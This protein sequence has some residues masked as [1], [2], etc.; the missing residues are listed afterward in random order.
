MSSS[1][2]D[3]PVERCISHLLLK[4]PLPKPGGPAVLVPLPALN[5]PMILSNPPGKDLPLVDLPFQRLFACLDVPTIVTIVV[6]LLSL[7]RKL[8]IVSTRPSLVLDVCE[9]LKALLFPFDLCAPYVPRLTE[10][11]VSCLDFPGAIFVGIFDDGTK[12][13]LASMVRSN[14]PE[15]SAIVDL[16]TGGINCSGDRYEVLK[17]CWNLIPAGPRSILVSEV[18]T[19]CRDAGIVP[20][21]EPLDSQV[22]S[23][24]DISVPFSSLVDDFHDAGHSER[25]PL[26]DR[27]VRDAFLRFFTSALAGYER[28]LVPPDLDFKTSGSEWFDT[29]GFIAAASQEQTPYLNNLVSTQLFQ[30]FIQRRTEDSDVHCLLFDECLIEYHSSSIPYGRLGGDVETV[31]SNNEGPPQMMYSLLVDQCCAESHHNFSNGSFNDEVNESETLQ[32]LPGNDDQHQAESHDLFTNEQGDL[33]TTPA[34]DGLPGFSQYVHV[35]DG[36]PCFPQKLN[37]NY[38]SPKEP[39][40]LL[41][42]ISEAPLPLLTRSEREIEEACRKRK[43]ATS[44]RGLNNQ[45]RC[46]WQ[47]PKLMGSHFLGTWLL[48]IPSQVSQKGIS[49]DEQVHFLHRA[50]G[51][52]R[53]LRNKQKIIPDEASYRALIVACGCVASDRRVELAK[54]FGLLRSDGIFPTAVTLGQYTR[55][56]A[57]GYSKRSTGPQE[58]TATLGVEV[59]VT[60]NENDAVNT[61]QSP[62]QEEAI[63]NSLDGNIS[64]LEESGRRWR[65]RLS[66]NRQSDQPDKAHKAEE[67]SSLGN[68]ISFDITVDEEPTNRKK[69]APKPWN[70]VLVSSSF[71]PSCGNQGS[72]SRDI[73]HRMTLIAIWSRTT[74]CNGCSYIPLD[75]EVQSGWDVP[76]DN[77]DQLNEVACPRCGSLLIPKIGY[78]KFTLEEA[79][80]LKIGDDIQ[81]EEKVPKADILPPQIRSSLENRNDILVSYLSPECM[82]SRLEKLVEEQG[83]SILERNSLSKL[84]PCLFYNFWWYCARF[85]LPLPLPITRLSTREDGSDEQKH[86]C[87]F[88]AWDKSTAERGCRAAAEIVMRAFSTPLDTNKLL[89]PRSAIADCTDGLSFSSLLKLQNLSKSDWDHVD[90]SKVLV[91]LVE[92]CDK[93]DFKPVVECVLN[94]L[95]RRLGEN[96]NITNSASLTSADM[97]CYRTILYLSKYQCTTAFHIFFP[98]ATKPCKGYHF[99][100]AFGTPLPIFDRLFHEAVQRIRKTEKYATPIH[101]VSDVAL[102]FRCVFGH[103]I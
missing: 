95:K 7:E 41:V 49:A 100:C 99:W 56:L 82:R 6:G 60:T 16:D 51:A 91:S 28:F 59:T 30:L 50:L 57:E 67:K 77:L 94:C 5:C 98:A 89:N 17:H 14:L 71:V 35:L 21:Q 101:D 79:L 31:L 10:P 47:L 8:L 97:D 40:S 103:I 72:L 93:R 23:A 42:E 22:D 92:A 36:N 53:L 1:P 88:A 39:D 54:L 12:N 74:R 29:Q 61:D 81:N 76:G 80:A 46:L 70:P 25:E 65:S 33:I 37:P 9:L 75:E 45:R 84:D 73:M 68:K 15:D 48:C 63:L 11:F 38:F 4:V 96:K 19:L 52:T 62:V 66:H 64:L 55:A 3:L 44:Y 83:E 87:A 26:D 13:G 27:A 43:K 86:E 24:F 18:E 2:S 102:G 20:G 78:K 69:G 90:L 58:D 32:I 85:S 34:R